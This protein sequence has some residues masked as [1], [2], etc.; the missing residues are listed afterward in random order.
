MGLPAGILREKFA[1]ETPVETRNAVGES[2]IAWQEVGTRLGSY[3]ANAYIELDR[4]GQV[5]GSVSATVRM[6]YFPGLTGKHR[7]RWVSRDN[8]LLYIS[9][10]VERGNRE[11]HELTVEEQ[12][13]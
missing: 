5:G 12:A 8:R 4:R 2:I 9:S 7:L 13:T 11:E 1:I 10:V 6:R 3:E